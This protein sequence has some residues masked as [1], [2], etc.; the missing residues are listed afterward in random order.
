M[1]LH[2]GFS[3]KESS[4]RSTHQTRYP[5]NEPRCFAEKKLKNTIRLKPQEWKQSSGAK[6]MRLVFSSSVDTRRPDFPFL[7]P[8]TVIL[9]LYASDFSTTASP[10]KPGLAQMRTELH[11][12]LCCCGLRG[13]SGYRSTHNTRAAFAN[14]SAF[15][16]ISSYIALERGDS[17][18]V[19]SAD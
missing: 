10:A 9:G 8:V 11:P 18:P 16:L 3:E 6:R 1:L 19:S 5:P 17:L 15:V 13:A 4:F 12:S 2:C 7:T 14:L